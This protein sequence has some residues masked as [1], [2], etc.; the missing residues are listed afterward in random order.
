MS[1]KPLVSIVTPTYNRQSFISETINSVLNQ[2]YSNIEYFVI[3]D[4]SSDGTYQFLTNKYGKRINILSNKKNLGQVATQNKGWSLCK[5]KYI[6]YL[7]DDDIL[8]PDAI[9]ELVSALEFNKKSVC[10][11]PDC[12]LI[13]KNSIIV[14]NNICRPFNLEDT[15][16]TQSCFIGPG[17]LFIRSAYNAVGRWNDKL[18]LGPDREFWI[19]M[20][21][22]GDIQMLPVIL[23]AYRAHLDS[24]S[25]KLP[26]GTLC[27]EYFEVLDNY[28]SKKYDIP[29]SIANRKNEAYASVYFLMA[30]F[31]LA[32]CN[33]AFQDVSW[34]RHLFGHTT[35]CHKLDC[36]SFTNRT[37]NQI[38]QCAF[39]QVVIH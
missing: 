21:Q 23:A 35:V 1:I 31:D 4:A 22:L 38:G 14:K 7:S 26:S 37:S 29:P 8:Y 15:L 5:G 10:V 2:T 28:Y 17:A 27:K 6:G 39:F 30:R 34:V 20:S 24:A 36:Q 16:I 32:R 13:D 19:R 3:D 25:I 18:R 12:N 9:K 33:N 11:F